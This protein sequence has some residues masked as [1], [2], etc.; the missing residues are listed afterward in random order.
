MQ[1]INFSRCAAGSGKKPTRKIQKEY[2][3]Q[4]DKNQANRRKEQA[5]KKNDSGCW[6][7]NFTIDKT[8]H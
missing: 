2:S 8:K 7:S 5:G 3:Y 1:R 6:F 4:L